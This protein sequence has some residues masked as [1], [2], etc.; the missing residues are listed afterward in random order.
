M[1]FKKSIFHK[2]RNVCTTFAQHS[3][4][5][6]T[7]FAQRNI[8]FLSTV[9]I[10]KASCSLVIKAMSSRSYLAHLQES[11]T[12]FHNSKHDDLAQSD[13]LDEKQ[14]ELDCLG[15]T[16]SDISDDEHKTDKH[17]TKGA[18]IV[19][20]EKSL[21]QSI[22]EIMRSGND[23]LVMKALAESTNREEILLTDTE[24]DG[25]EAQH[26]RPQQSPNSEIIRIDTRNNVNRSAS[27]SASV[28]ASSASDT[29]SG[30]TIDSSGSKN[31]TNRVVKRVQLRDVDELTIQEMEIDR[32]FAKD[33]RDATIGTYDSK[34]ESAWDREYS[35]DW[36]SQ[37]YDPD[38]APSSAHYGNSVFASKIYTGPTKQMP[39]YALYMYLEVSKRE[40]IQFNLY[41]F[42]K[43][44]F[45]VMILHLYMGIYDAMF[46]V[47]TIDGIVSCLIF[48]L[49]YL[50]F[51]NDNNFLAKIRLITID[52]YIYYL[53]MFVGVHII[54]YVT[55]YQY[56][57][58]TRYMASF[59]IC[60][61]I[62]GQIYNIKGYSKVR[63]VLYDGYNNLIKKIVCK[64][65]SKIIN[66]FIDN[67]LRL[68]MHVEY[69][70][71][72]EHYEDLDFLIINRFIVTFILALIFNH[73][74]KGSLKIPIMIYKNLYM[75]DS[76][77]NITDDK[78]YL[79]RIIRDR[80]WEKFLDIYTLNRMIRMLIE[81]DDKDADLS[82]MINDLIKRLFFRINRVMFC[83]TVMS[84]SGSL[85][86]GV[87][88]FL[89]FLRDAS[90]P[91]RYLLN[92]AVFGGLSFVSSEQLL[93][94]ILCEICFTVADSKLVTDVTRDTYGS[95]RRGLANVYGNTR[96]ESIVVSALLSFLSALSLNTVSLTIVLA[97]NV[98]LFA[99]FKTHDLNLIRTIEAKPVKNE[100][101]ELPRVSSIDG[102]LG[103]FR[104]V[105][106][107]FTAQDESKDD[108]KTD[109]T[110]YSIHKNSDVIRYV[111]RSVQSNL[112]YR[113][114]IGRTSDKYDL[115]RMLCYY[116]TLLVFGYISGFA[117]M[118]SALLL[119]IIQNLVD[120]V[121]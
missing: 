51:E 11:G 82:K 60:P 75:K 36:L 49:S 2:L 17:K 18:E 111:I 118:H 42:L 28:S 38:V 43:E 67:V 62:M 61:S 88:S 106:D 5:I 21:S 23:E 95:L 120:I 59:I 26:T 100:N 87:L 90:K 31:Q 112:L 4:N 65:L 71:L 91:F 99:R 93:I 73:V 40:Q 83:W 86:L 57:E 27:A 37:N 1:M 41:D 85:T 29:S 63:K 34:W 110:D 96:T 46:N 55:W 64:Q 24:S 84:I 58:V 48:Y 39:K 14:M 72:M 53:L 25:D 15:M 109:K 107:V 9:N 50:G 35:E 77:Y 70:E 108:A 103:Y 89:M 32:Q 54:N 114:I 33:D 13:F 104:N 10:H 102:M 98:I 101:E 105:T 16:D 80:R 52:R 8:E 78:M 119:I 76:K 56:S 97:I 79:S 19:D 115:Y 94:L 74:D 117:T 30:I 81:N 69:T 121:W 6:R 20:L 66:M 92:V 116:F 3:H 12:D 68:R 22:T 45:I 7:T 44:L 47:I 113:T